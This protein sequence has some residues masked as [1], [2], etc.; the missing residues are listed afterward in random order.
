MNRLNL[1]D[2]LSLGQELMITMKDALPSNLARRIRYT[3]RNGDSLSAIA[4][5]YNVDV[6]DITNLNQIGIT[7]YIRPGQ[8]LL[9][10]ISN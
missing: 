6:N 4:N 7:D 9:I 1:N 2:S 5:R 8:D 3:V 10:D